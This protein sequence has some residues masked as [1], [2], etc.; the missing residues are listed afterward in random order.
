MGY[1]FWQG[2]ERATGRIA[3]TGMGLLQFKAN[4]EHQQAQ[5]VHNEAVLKIAQDKAEMEK[6]TWD[7][8]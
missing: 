2:A 3:E 6:K 8:E 5:R 1:G 7:Y 4:Q